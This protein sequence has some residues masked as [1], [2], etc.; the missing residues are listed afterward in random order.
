MPTSLVGSFSSF[1]L[2]T[3]DTILRLLVSTIERFHFII[4]QSISYCHIGNFNASSK[5]CCQGLQLDFLALKFGFSQIIKK[6]TH[7]L[8]NSKSCVGLIFTYANW[9]RCWCIFSPALSPINY[10][11]KSWFK[12]ILSRTLLENCEAYQKS[13]AS[14][15]LGIRT[16]N[17]D[18]NEQVSAF[19]ST[20]TNFI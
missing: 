8:K 7:I 4:R 2:S 20:N 6:Q 14:L 17:L 19:N 18:T 11:P 13:N 16:N 12:D 5:H 1:V 9:H 3:A 10:I 15:C